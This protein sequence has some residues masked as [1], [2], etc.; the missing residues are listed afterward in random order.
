VTRRYGGSKTE[1]AHFGDPPA[2]RGDTVPMILAGGAGER[3]GRSRLVALL[4]FV[5]AFAI[6]LP[7]TVHGI[8][9]SDV[10]SANFA[11]WH[12]VT[13]GTPHIDGLDIPRFAHD[14]NRAVWIHPLPDGH[15]VIGRAP[16]VIAVTLP[17][18]WLLHPAAM[19]LLPGNLTAALLA[20]AAVAM[21][22]LALVRR[23][24]VP[25]AALAALVFGFATPM[26]SISANGLWPQ[27]VTTFGF[28]GM[29]WACESKRWWLAG[30]F[31]G[32]SLWARLPVAL[33]VAVVGV[34]VGRRRG[35]RAIVLQIGAVS[36][37]FL[38]LMCAWSR[39]MFDSWNP[40]ASY[41]EATLR[42]HAASN[43]L[44]LVNQLGAWV[45]PDRG[46]VVWTPVLLLLLPALVRSWGDLPDWSR[47]L[48]AAGLAYTVVQ[49]SLGSFTG[50]YVFYGYRYG[51]TFVACAT[52]ALA[53]SAPRMGAVARR[54]F[55]PVVGLQLLAFAMGA[56]FDDLWLNSSLAWRDNAFVHSLRLLGPWGWV[57]AALSVALGIAGGRLWRLRLVGSADSHDVEAHAVAT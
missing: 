31:G 7:T 54:L 14:P 57:L 24:G 18:Y 27:T 44:N 9:S 45:A 6:Y 49:S 50:G 43:A 20:A 55:G 28:A 37:L 15:T 21:M 13:T 46:I 26:W 25:Q 51:L 10:W 56:V 3:A 52:P 47:A 17:A 2:R 40:V 11:S 38:V 12:L 8:V 53:L 5:V 1:L 48:V 22:F 42:D 35:D 34:Y 23:L 33:I 39:W 30:V 41:D 19:T 32:I 36:G 4:L 29:A 16:G